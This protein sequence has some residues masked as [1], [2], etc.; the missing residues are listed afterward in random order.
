VLEALEILKRREAQAE[1]RTDCRTEEKP[2]VFPGRGKSG[3]LVEPA[4]A[5]ERIRNR[6]GLRDVRIHDLRRT[7][8]SWQAAFG[9]SLSIIGKTLAHKN[10]STTA[11]YARLNLDPVR[12][13]MKVA[14]QAMLSAAGAPAHQD[15]RDA[16]AARSGRSTE[17]QA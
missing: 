16:A 7:L 14:T 12:E 6:A 11:I 3:H 15:G 1:K 4:K 13:S 5:W 10:V 8:G 2:W 9:A 17:D